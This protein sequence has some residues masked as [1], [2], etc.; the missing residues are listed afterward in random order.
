MNMTMAVAASVAA[1]TYDVAI[2]FLFQDRRT[3]QALH[4]ELATSGLNVFF[5]PRRQEELAGTNGME[6]MRTPFLGARVNVVLFRKPWGETPWTRVEDTAISER[7]FKGGWTTLMFVQLDKTSTLP[8]WLPPTH[9]RFSFDDYGLTQLVGAIKLRVQEQGGAIRRVDAMGK[10]E[11]VRREA[12]YLA[13]RDRLMRDAGWIGELQESIRRAMDELGRLASEI[14]ASQRLDIVVGPGNF[15]LTIIRSGYVSMAV[16]WQQPISN[17]VGDSNPYECHLW[18]AEHS[19]TLP[20]HGENR[21]YVEQP[22][23]M[24]QHTFKV[25]VARD[26]GLMW[27][28]SGK[29]EYIQPSELADYIMRLFLDL[30]DRANKGKVERP[31]L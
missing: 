23:K 22:K 12:E 20:L 17:Y 13:D 5:F 26:R 7:C 11:A 29:N 10:A 15:G 8:G 21:W 1:P 9:V 2:S 25:D 19:G 14:N 28:A 27:R 4:D 31:H 6:S 18:A 24:R 16:G 30:V 3:A